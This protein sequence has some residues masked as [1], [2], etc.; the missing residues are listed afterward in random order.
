MTCC[1]SDGVELANQ[2]N[3]LAQEHLTPDSRPASSGIVE[4]SVPVTVW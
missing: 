1:L 3:R 2:P 4:R